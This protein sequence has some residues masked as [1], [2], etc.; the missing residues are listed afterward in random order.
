MWS[1]SDGN[2]E[3]KLTLPSLVDAAGG[4]RGESKLLVITVGRENIYFI[5]LTRPFPL[6][7]HHEDFFLS[8]QF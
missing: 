5:Y 7:F 6:Y 2:K 4:G 1:L 8:S 3:L